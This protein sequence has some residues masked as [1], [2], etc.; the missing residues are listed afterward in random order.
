M[1]AGDLSY[2]FWQKFTLSGTN[3][4]FDVSVQ[5]KELNSYVA[6]KKQ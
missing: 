3:L 4:V 6:M 2:C 1:V 5:I